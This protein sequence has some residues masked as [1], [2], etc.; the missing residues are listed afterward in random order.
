MQG[1]H[2]GRAGRTWRA[3]VLGCPVRGTVGVMTGAAPDAPT[4][5]AAR[6]LA[7]TL[8]RIAARDARFGLELLTPGRDALPAAALHDPSSPDLDR[9]LSA[10]AAGLR[11]GQGTVV[12]SSL[13][14][15]YARALTF[16]AMAA[17]VLEARA[18]DLSASGMSVRR[19]E[20]GAFAGFALRAVR[21]AA[22]PSDPLAGNPRVPA[23]A[24]RVTLAGWLLERLVDRHLAG[25]VDALAAATGLSQRVLRGNVAAACLNPFT[26]LVRRSAD[27]D[28]TIDLARRTWARLPAGLA[29]RVRLRCEVAGGRRGVFVERDTC[30]LAFRTPDARKC[31]GC[32][33]LDDGERRQRRRRELL[34]G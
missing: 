13:A 9:M 12:A 19:D 17:L 10:H 4:L 34:A 33:L 25:L 14:L 24:D 2:G 31:G 28:A 1:R 23:V 21:F 26:V 32:S 30:C 22:L 7:G 15:R 29:G 20:S 5:A 3:V 11:V 18:P 27:P 8:R 16:P 6:A